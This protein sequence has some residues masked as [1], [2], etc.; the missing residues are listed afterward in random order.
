MIKVDDEGKGLI[1]QI[2][3]ELARATGIQHIGIISGALSTMEDNK[4]VKKKKVT[5]KR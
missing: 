2:C 3:H 4:P 5:K 1:Q